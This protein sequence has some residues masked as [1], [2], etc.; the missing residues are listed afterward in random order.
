MATKST[1]QPL[2]NDT[3]PAN[4]IPTVFVLQ[5]E[6]YPLICEEVLDKNDSDQKSIGKDINND[7]LKF[8]IN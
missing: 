6:K 7:P 5:I 4:G 1:H 8:L 2:E 3:D